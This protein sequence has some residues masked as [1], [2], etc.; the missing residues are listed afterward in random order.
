MPQE[1]SLRLSELIMNWLREMEKEGL[2]KIVNDE[3]IN[4]RIRLCD[5]PKDYPYEDIL[6]HGVY[7]RI[8]YDDLGHKHVVYVLR[9]DCGSIYLSN[10][11]LNDYSLFKKLF[12]NTIKKH[13][14]WFG[15]LKSH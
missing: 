13:P 4:F 6:I 11:T 1:I 14:E 2:L 5:M 3:F 9:I 15:C 8:E 10:A 7:R 12:L